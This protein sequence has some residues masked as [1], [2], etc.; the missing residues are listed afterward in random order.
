MPSPDTPPRRVLVV[1]DYAG[2]RA[3]LTRVLRFWG[4]EV[5]TAADGL[6]GV[7][8]A[9]A[10]GPDVALVDVNLPGLNGFDVA[11][12]VRA[13]LGGRVTLVALTAN[14][15]ADYRRR[16]AEAGFDHF[17]TKPPDLALL[18]RLVAGHG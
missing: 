3:V 2:Y 9:L 10:S 18:Q 7:E 11:Q 4:H 17:L 16:A 5:E 12:R 13:A 1:E 8:K 14:H 6:E 15:D